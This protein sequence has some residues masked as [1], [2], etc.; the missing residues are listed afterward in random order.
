MDFLDLPSYLLKKKAL[1]TTIGNEYVC[2][3]LSMLK[4][5]RKDF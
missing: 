5:S 2:N 4:G 3:E 1:K